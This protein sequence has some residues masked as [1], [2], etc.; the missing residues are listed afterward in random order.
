MSNTILSNPAERQYARDR[1][2]SRTTTGGR[3][4]MHTTVV[5]NVNGKEYGACRQHD[6]YDFT[7]AREAKK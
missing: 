5:V 1:C 3:C 2:E 7:P 6:R 4:R